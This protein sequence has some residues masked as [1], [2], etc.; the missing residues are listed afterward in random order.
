VDHR[1]FAVIVGRHECRV[2]GVTNSAQ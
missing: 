2:H 1:K